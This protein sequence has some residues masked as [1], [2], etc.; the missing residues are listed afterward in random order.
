MATVAKKQRSSTPGGPDGGSTTG[1]LLGRLDFLRAN[2]WMWSFLP[3]CLIY[4]VLVVTHMSHLL[5][6]VYGSSDT[7]SSLV[8]AEFFA[9]RG[10][11]RVVLGTFPWYS[12]LIFLE[13]TKWLPLHRQI[14]ELGPYLMALLSIA[15][16]SWA[17]LRVAGRWA[18]ALTAVILLCAG[19]VVLELMLWLPNH[20]STWYSLALLAAFLVLMTKHGGS[21]GRLPLAMLTLFVG[22]MEGVNVASDKE[23]LIAGILPLLLAGIITWALIRT[24]LSA[25]TMWLA[26]AVAAVAGVSAIVTTSTMDSAG[27]VASG[28]KLKFVGFEALSKNVETW[29]QSIALLGN[30]PFLGEAITFTTTVALGCAA[31]SLAAVLY[32]PRYTW[33]YMSALRAGGKRLDEQLT[34]YMIFWTT[35][36]VCLCA[37]FILST[38]PYGSQS[39]RYL[40]GVV[41]AV[42]AMLPL[43]ARSSTVLRT[44]VVAG[45][46]VFL[47]G[48]TLS[49]EKDGALKLP[50]PNRGPSPQVALDVA[51]TAEA[52]HTTFG[53]GL[54]WDAA[55]ITWRANFRVLVAPLVGCPVSSATLCPGPHNYLETWYY[56]V[57]R[58]TFVLTDPSITPWTPPATLGPAIAKYT[59]GTVTMY[60]YGYDVAEKLFY[61]S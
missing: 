3:L 44:A 1:R 45:A 30:G 5:L 43:L 22:V 61:R 59:F 10:V 20:T 48:A 40:V 60:F 29:L 46:L 25:R 53:Y 37:G 17:A 51:R 12:T 2:W 52:M 19:P 42:A 47:F 9:S 32:I 24:E 23:L 26:L 27:I 11:G 18:A 49:L 14:W 31:V 16:M 41:Y 7:S 33:R 15:L 58:R 4:L 38:A 28:F 13:A 6:N 55:A 34:V 39:T 35:S 56:P 8:E 54:Y 50:S 21:V 36:L 57:S